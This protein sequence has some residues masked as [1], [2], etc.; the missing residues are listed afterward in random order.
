MGGPDVPKAHAKK[1]CLALD[2]GARPKVGQPVG[3]VEDPRARQSVDPT[4]ILPVPL[5][6]PAALGA[7]AGAGHRVSLNQDLP[8]RWEVD[9][10]AAPRVQ[11]VLGVPRFLRARYVWGAQNI[12]EVESVQGARKEG[13]GEEAIVHA[14][15]IAL[16]SLDPP[17]TEAPGHRFLHFRTMALLL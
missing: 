8:I 11:R 10:K 1:R 9:P 2:P 16:E 17:L 14:K 4:A 7:G 13:L 3:R 6:L 12:R 15:R 5:H